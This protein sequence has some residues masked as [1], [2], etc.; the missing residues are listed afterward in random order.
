MNIREIAKRANV[1]I[2]TVSRTINRHQTVDPKLAKRVWK[3]IEEIGYYPNTQARA[4]V[5]GKSRILGLIV[6]EITNPFFPEVVQSFENTAVANGYEILVTSTVH[7]PKRMELAVRRMIERRVDGV[8]VLTFGFEE[9]LT[10]DLRYRKIPL[11]FV[12]VGPLVPGV[13]NIRI[14]YMNGIRQA[15][16]HIAALRHERIAFVTGPLTLQSAITRRECFERSMQEIGLHVAPEY[17]VEANHTLEGGMRAF[18]RIAKLRERPT[19]VFCSNDMTAIGVMREAYEYGISVP[20]EISVVGF[21]NIRLCEFTTP[22][23]TTVEMSQVGLARLAFRALVEELE[24][25]EEAGAP[26]E[27]TL[28]TNL[29][30]RRSTALAQAARAASKKR[31]RGKEPV[32]TA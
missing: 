9:T 24:D 7:E 3:V 2:S 30:L 31:A 10:A 29:V 32:T 18:A 21:D 20:R 28:T 14:N 4:L 27:Y 16:Q 26:R 23:L 1:S 17:I 6:S 11:V 15:V 12:D 8:A 19:A 13:A 5:S 22:P 25:K